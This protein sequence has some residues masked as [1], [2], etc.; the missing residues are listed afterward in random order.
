MSEHE[1]PELRAP[2]AT[3]IPDLGA[4]HIRK[5]RSPK[6]Y[7]RKVPLKKAAAAQDGAGPK[8]HHPNNR[9]TQLKASASQSQL[10]STIPESLAG[11]MATMASQSEGDTQPLSEGA[12]EEFANKIREH[13]AVRQSEAAS[14]STANWLNASHTFQ[15]GETGHIDILEGFEQPMGGDTQEEEE[16]QDDEI[17]PYSQQADIRVDLFPES[18]R[19]QPP[20][21]PATTSRKRQRVETSIGT[22]HTTPGLP[23]NPFAGQPGGRDGMMN[24]SQAFKA[25]QYTSPLLNGPL[26][27]ALSDRPSPDL[28]HAQRPSTAD[29]VSSPIHQTRS[30]MIRAVTEPQTTYI[31]MAESQAERDRRKREVEEAQQAAGQNNSD[32]DFDSEDSEIRRRR[33]RRKIELDSRDIFASVTAKARPVPNRRGRGGRR[34]QTPRTASSRKRNKFESE[35]VIISD[36]PVAEGNITEDETEHEEMAD[37]VSDPDNSD[38]MTEENKENFNR[39]DLQIPSTTSRANVRRAPDNLD[40][41]TPSRH[42]SRRSVGP[43]AS[44]HQRNTSRQST[45]SAEVVEERPTATTTV[46]IADSQPSHPT[47]C[48]VSSEPIQG[49]T[50]VRESPEEQR[51]FVPRSQISESTTNYSR[52]HVAS[53]ASEAPTYIPASSTSPSLQRRKPRTQPSRSLVSQESS[54]EAAHPPQSLETPTGSHDIQSSPPTVD[55]V[56]RKSALQ[57]PANDAMQ[58]QAILA[59]PSHVAD[60]EAPDLHPSIAFNVNKLTSSAPGEKVPHRKSPRQPKQLGSFRTIP[61]TSSAEGNF[62]STLPSS[63]AP[64]STNTSSRLNTKI[65]SS[66][67]NGASSGPSTLFETALTHIT[68]SPNKQNAGAMAEKEASTPSPARSRTMLEIANAASPPG[69]LDDMDIDINILTA[70]DL[71]FQAAINGSSPIHPARKRRRGHAGRVL[72]VEEPQSDDRITPQVSALNKE[73]A[74]N[75]IVDAVRPTKDQ[76]PVDNAT[77]TTVKAPRSSSPAEQGL[78]PPTKPVSASKKRG[79]PKKASINADAATGPIPTKGAASSPTRA[80]TSGLPRLQTTSDPQDADEGILANASVIAPNQVFAHFNGN[81]PAFYPAT[82]IGLAGGEETQY[83]VRFDDGTV[84]IINGFGIKRLELKAGDNVKIDTGGNRKKTYVVV[85]MK[86]NEQPILTSDP[87]TPAR[88]NPHGR[89][90]TTIPTLT[91]IRG[92]A[93]VVVAQKQPNGQEQQPKET[94]TVPLKDVYFTQTMWTS[95]KDRSYT[96]TPVRHHLSSHLETPLERSSIPSTPSSRSHRIKTSG[97]GP[98][99]SA[100]TS[101]ASESTLFDNM[102]FAVT[103]IVEPASR[104]ALTNLI[105]KHGGHL[106]SEDFSELFHIPPLGPSS[107]SKKSPKR[108]VDT[109]FHLTAAASR[110]GF[111]CLIAD[112]HCRMAKYIQALALGIP[113][114]SSRWVEDCISQQSIQPWE[115]YLLAAGESSFLNGAIRSRILPSFDPLTTNLAEMVEAR[116]KPLDK[117]SLL[118][119]MEKGEDS[120]MVSHPLLSYAL[121]AATVARVSSAEAANTMLG[122]AEAKGETW[123]WVYSHDKEDKVEKVLLGGRGKDGGVGRKRKRG[124]S[125]GGRASEGAGRRIRVVGNEF[126]V[127]SLILGRLVD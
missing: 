78:K 83:R 111:T 119:I 72:H 79:R 92:Y 37:E 59:E 25:T 102:V 47:N 54:R 55:T 29:P 33:I 22:E 74:H 21:T 52:G 99:R 127:Q 16:I 46:A 110:M 38:E 56:G 5:G 53:T 105:R 45:A 31:S 18:R 98:S 34:Q 10:P 58:A 8:E 123:D 104:T 70:D 62:A 11:R 67:T 118:L 57:E 91:D 117:S 88:R 13:H 86:N 100:K 9:D 114:L 68:I 75:E 108:E 48:G 50:Q 94:V 89:V 32:D 95:L 64:P 77:P 49:H 61:A 109:T 69:A 73:D 42:Q 1:Q 66:E 23:I 116:P 26:S 6:I 24:A 4:A 3:K 44:I 93:S 113:C 20:I 65:T 80:S 112:K 97:L 51:L 81:C 126:V 43:E 41:E 30:R 120:I 103:N 17:D 87:E 121:G 28:F 101:T 124:G 12:R 96:Y 19:F 84:D 60:S 115:P 36:D 27:D 7:S 71:E 122:D 39:K 125:A 85:E 90:A 63:A 106:L 76:P 14:E 107:P 40:L 2:T 35:A 82:C 15:P